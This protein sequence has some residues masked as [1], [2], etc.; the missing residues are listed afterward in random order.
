MVPDL[1][2]DND[3][4]PLIWIL[5]F[6]EF[7]TSPCSFYDRDP[8]SSLI[9]ILIQLERHGG[10]IAVDQDGKRNG[11]GL[12][13]SGSETASLVKQNPDACFFPNHFCI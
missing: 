7:R 13:G 12:M 11:S 9:Q 1:D 8:K 2:L 10:Q 6:I 3:P 4:D 5:T